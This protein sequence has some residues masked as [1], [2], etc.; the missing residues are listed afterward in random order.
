MKNNMSSN[1]GPEDDVPLPAEIFDTKL[2]LQEIATV[3]LLIAVVNGAE[4]ESDRCNDEDVQAA[5]ESL[6]A[7]GIIT[8]DTVGSHVKIGVHL[9][10]A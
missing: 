7:K 2:S 6:K 10:E 4:I 1:L 3:A 5:M 9:E 8:V